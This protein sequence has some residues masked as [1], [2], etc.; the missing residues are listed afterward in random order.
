MN[1]DLIIKLAKL[2]NN[3]PNDHEANAAARKVCRLL[4]EAN[5]KF[6]ADRP[7]ITRTKE[8][9]FSSKYPPPKKS[10]RKA[11]PE[12]NPFR[13][14]AYNTPFD[15]AFRDMYDK[16][17]SWSGRGNPFGFNPDYINW[18]E[19]RDKKKE[20]VER[21]CSRCNLKVKTYSK[22]EP[23][24]CT[25]CKTVIKNIHEC[26]KCKSHGWVLSI[27]TDSYFCTFCSYEITQREADANGWRMK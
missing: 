21:V 6:E 24:V 19:E 13:G 14:S 5:F 22:E 20:D 7:T 16:A 26:P 8:P 2:A 15:Q 11:E 27:I 9:D 17:N 4:A 18:K 10:T 1:F 12:R 25:I 23:F 3:N